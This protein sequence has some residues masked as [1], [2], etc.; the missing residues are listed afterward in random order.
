MPA[1]G[2][3]YPAQVQLLDYSGERQGIPNLYVGALS[4]TTFEDQGTLFDT[5]LT[6]LDAIVIGTIAKSGYGLAEVI[7]NTKP[8][9]KAAQ[10]ESEM[11]VSLIDAATSAPFS[12]RIPTIDYTA[13]N[14]G[15]GDAG[16]EVIISGAGATAATTDFVTAVN[17]VMRSPFNPANFATVVGMRVVK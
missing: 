16:D 14:Y 17:A 9:S 5:F 2:V 4:D 12:F 6:A 13:F 15:T 7:S 11:L 1:I 8:A 3:A 10:I